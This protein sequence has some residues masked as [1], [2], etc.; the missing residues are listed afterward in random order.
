ML[1]GLI[2]MGPPPHGTDDK[3]MKTFLLVI[4]FAIA[5]LLS[6]SGAILWAVVNVA[7]PPRKKEVRRIPAA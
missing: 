4:A 3:V 6:A 1:I 2:S 5:G 7:Y